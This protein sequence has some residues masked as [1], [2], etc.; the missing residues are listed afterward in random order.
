MPNGTMSGVSKSI[1]KGVVDVM[2]EPNG[3]QRG[4]TSVASA[5]IVGTGGIDLG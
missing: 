2:G 3:N 1:E 5:S 4:S